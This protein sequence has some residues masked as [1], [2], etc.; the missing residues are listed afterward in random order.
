MIAE[1]YDAFR[2]AG[3]SDEKARAAAVALNSMDSKFESLEAK[4]DGRFTA[5]DT[6]FAAIDT[7]FAGVDTRLAKIDTE[8]AVLRWMSGTAIVL[9]LAILGKLLTVH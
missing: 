9:S 7:K 2:D 8:L 3:A 5:L 4:L 6:K 1:V